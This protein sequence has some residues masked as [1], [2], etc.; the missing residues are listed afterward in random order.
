MSMLQLSDISEA[1]EIDG[2][3]LVMRRDV[4]VGSSCRL[5]T[6][7]RSSFTSQSVNGLTYWRLFLCKMV[8]Y[9]IKVRIR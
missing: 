9:D 5:A 4:R 7:C 1:V 3:G 8:Y 2:Y 6:V